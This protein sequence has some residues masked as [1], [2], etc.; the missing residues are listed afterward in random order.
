MD[1]PMNSAEKQ[2]LDQPLAVASSVGTDAKDPEFHSGWVEWII[3]NLVAG[4]NSDRLVQAMLQF[5]FSETFATARVR[6][7]EQSPTIQAARK[8]VAV[9]RKAAD[10]LDA[11]A[12]LEQKSPFNKQV[13]AVQG[14]PA[15]DFYRDYFFRSC[16]VLLR[17]L[18]ANWK[19]VRLWT[20]DYFANRF[21]D[22]EVD[23]TTG[24]NADPAHESNYDQHKTQITMRDYVQMVVEGGETNDYYMVAKNYLLS[25]PEFHELYDHFSA[26]DG[27]L[28]ANN[29]K[30]KVRVWFGPKGT[31]SQLHHDSGPIL[32]AQIYGRKQVKLISPYHLASVSSDGE[33]LSPVDPDH[34]DYARFPGMR[35]VDVLE[36]TLEPG[37]ILFVPLGWWH[38]VKALDVSISLS[39]DNFWVAREEVELCWQ[40]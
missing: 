2:P 14:L 39:F 4:A 16:P 6:E 10:I 31:I 35:N 8:V 15:A 23:I 11:L 20:P 3:S 24:R 12:R 26:P 32:L 1:A 22:Y 28:D 38:W 9:Q 21:G 7:H 29:M 18:T 34:V 25:R 36:V 30:N 13:D 40:G 17:G 27:Y 37:E 5:G 33:W 19:A